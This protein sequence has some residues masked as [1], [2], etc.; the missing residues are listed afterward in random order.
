MGIYSTV[1]TVLENDNIFYEDTGSS[2]PQAILMEAYVSLLEDDHKLFDTL[3]EL[4]FVEAHNRNILTESDFQIV[5]ENAASE[6]IKGI[7]AKVKAFFIKIKN[8]VVNAIKKFFGKAKSKQVEEDDKALVDKYETILSKADATNGMDDFEY[9][10]ANNINFREIITKRKFSAYVNG[11]LTT[12]IDTLTTALDKYST[13]TKNA[14]NSEEGNNNKISF[15]TGNDALDGYLGVSGGDADYGSGIEKPDSDENKKVGDVNKIIQDALK[16]QFDILSDKEIK[17]GKAS[18]SITITKNITDSAFD[19][20]KNYSK[21]ENSV[22]GAAKKID[23]FYAKI[24]KELKDAEAEVKSEFAGNLEKRQ[25]ELAKVEKRVAKMQS[26]YTKFLGIYTSAIS[27]ALSIIAEYYSFC[28]KIIITSGNYALKN[29]VYSDLDR[30]GQKKGDKL[31]IQN[32]SASF[33]LGADVI[34]EMVD[35]EI[36]EL[37]GY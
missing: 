18:G 5:T 23:K 2:S 30:N 28:K 7:W 8:A 25:K 3:I 29:G 37:F 21:L 35:A 26:I 24:E 12:M 14:I 6:K 31:T 20:I 27:K 15:S 11:F 13:E 9:T 1:S 16:S 17:K 33:G 4:D 22:N 10:S 36:E 34:S 32:N 19:F